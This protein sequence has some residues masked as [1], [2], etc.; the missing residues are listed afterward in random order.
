MLNEFPALSHGVLTSTLD[1]R[2]Y[3][4]HLTD[5]KAGT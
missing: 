5:N 2:Y 3:S 1:G 4:D